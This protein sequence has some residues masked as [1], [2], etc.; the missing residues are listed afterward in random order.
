[1]RSIVFA[2][3][4][5]G[6][7]WA[8]TQSLCTAATNREPV[9]L[10]CRDYYDHG[11]AGLWLDLSECEIAWDDVTYIEGFTGD[12][13]N[14][15]LPLVPPGFM[16]RPKIIL[17]SED[18]RLRTTIQM[19]LEALAT[20]SE[21]EL[22]T[23]LAGRGQEVI[24]LQRYEGL[25]EYGFTEFEDEERDKMEALVTNLDEDYI[26][27]K[28]EAK[29]RAGFGA[30]MLLIGLALVAPLR[31]FLRVDGS[32]SSQ[33]PLR[34]PADSPARSFPGPARRNPRER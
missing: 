34:E 22:E 25:K 13:T 11:A 7:I 8:G 33:P 23:F 3:M 15:M 21:D 26:V 1:M 31:R 5:A 2:I 32:T 29:P 17:S 27:V 4:G 30:V 6:A 10:T 20:G 19:L 18:S 12:I 14:V 24:G 28:H 9:A 16:G